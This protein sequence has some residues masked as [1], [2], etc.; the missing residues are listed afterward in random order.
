MGDALV[1]DRCG[2]RGDEQSEEEP[3]GVGGGFDHGSDGVGSGGIPGG[4]FGC[5]QRPSIGA[6]GFLMIGG[7]AG[8]ACDAGGGEGGDAEDGGIHDAPF[9]SAASPNPGSLGRVSGRM[10][11]FHGG[12]GWGVHATAQR[13]R[14]LW[15]SG[16]ERLTRRHEGV[17]WSCSGSA[18]GKTTPRLSVSAGS[19]FCQGWDGEGFARRRGERRGR[20]GRVG[21]CQDLM[22]RT[23]KTATPP[24]KKVAL[25]PTRRN[26]DSPMRPHWMGSP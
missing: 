2:G 7:T 16:W 5:A 3:G 13:S 8:A 18:H 26:R 12:W 4:L 9:A 22:S 11:E 17:E 1:Q 6:D 21:D 23:L 20:W 10:Q 25:K 15:G 14:R 19:V 24:A